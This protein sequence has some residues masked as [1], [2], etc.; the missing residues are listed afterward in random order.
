M[1]LEVNSE[2]NLEHHDSQHHSEQNWSLQEWINY[3]VQSTMTEEQ[4]HMNQV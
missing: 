1:N 3:E 4:S 2:Q